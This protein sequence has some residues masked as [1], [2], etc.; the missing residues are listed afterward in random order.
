MQL[1][2][3]QVVRSN[4]YDRSPS[5]I[6]EYF[7]VTDSGHGKTLRASYTVPADRVA[8]ISQ[9]HAT[10]WRSTVASAVNNVFSHYEIDNESGILQATN[11]LYQYGNAVGDTEH[12]VWTPDMLLPEG[13]TVELFTQ[14]QSTG[15]DMWYILTLLGTEYDA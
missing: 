6:A 10:V 1:G 12:R 5:P 15:G 13:W 9:I 2:Q 3:A 4:W 11:R 14:D 7:S 8:H